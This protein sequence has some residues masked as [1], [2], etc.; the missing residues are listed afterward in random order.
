[1]EL[2][3]PGGVA[4]EREEEWEEE[5][6][7][8]QF[9]EEEEWAAPER[10]P[11]LMENAYAQSAGLRFPIRLECLVPK[12]CVQIAERPWLGNDWGG[13]LW[14]KRKKFLMAT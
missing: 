6:A 9:G 5:A 1:M 10:E 13:F 4:R 2:A 14:M 7:G 11:A 12:R 3:L 8:E